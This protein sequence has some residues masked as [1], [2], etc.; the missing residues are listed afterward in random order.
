ML[1]RFLLFANVTYYARG[2]WN[3]FVDSFDT[4]DDATNAVGRTRRDID[5]W[6][7]VDSTTGQKVV[8]SS[9]AYGS[10]DEDMPTFTPP[11]DCDAL[12]RPSF[13]ERRAANDAALDDIRKFVY[14]S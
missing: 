5:W 9:G 14:G 4:I 1:K 2:G 11:T 13:G 8:I 6:H 7:V 12:G 3:D 10:V